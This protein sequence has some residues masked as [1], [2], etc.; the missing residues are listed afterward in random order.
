MLRKPKNIKRGYF[1]VSSKSKQF[2]SKGVQG[3]LYCVNPASGDPVEPFN[4][5]YRVDS[6][7][8]GIISTL[9][10]SD[11]WR[12]YGNKSIEFRGGSD[13]N[14]LCF[15][16]GYKSNFFIETFYTFVDPLTLGIL[17]KITLY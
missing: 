3:G 1:G 4:V 13:S 6:N 17:R 5:F 7:T 14:L 8:L 12:K 11:E 10:I 2:Y 9:T 16:S 15:H